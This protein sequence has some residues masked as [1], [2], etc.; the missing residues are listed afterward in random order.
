[1]IVDEFSYW[2]ATY[3]LKTKNE[4]VTSTYTPQHNGAKRATDT[5]DYKARVSLIFNQ[6]C[7]D[8]SAPAAYL[9]IRSTCWF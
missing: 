7:Y 1:M 3:P 9:H 2:I 6:D 4:A 8:A 5:I